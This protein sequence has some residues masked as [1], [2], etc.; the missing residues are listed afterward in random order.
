MTPFSEFV[1]RATNTVYLPGLVVSRPAQRRRKLHGLGSTTSS[2]TTQQYET[3]SLQAA[4]ASAN[5][6][7]AIRV[8]SVPG[9]IGAAGQLAASG[10]AIAGLI[11]GSAAIPVVGAAIAAAAGIASALGVGQGCGSACTNAA[12][13]EQVYEAAA[14][15]L[16]NVAK[17]GLISGQD[18][19]ALMQ[20]LIQMAQ[21]AEASQGTK[22][23]SSGASNAASVIQAE[24][25]SALQFGAATQPFSL[26]AAQAAFMPV[27]TSG[28]YPQ[29]LAA[30]SQLAAQI[31]Q[32]YASS[33]ASTSSLTGTSTAAA[34]PQV[35]GSTAAATT[36]STSTGLFGLSSAALL[37]IGAGV[38]L[39]MM[40]H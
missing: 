16:F 10:T 37:A 38:L 19:A 34:G 39:L 28:W 21:L 7:G 31:L 14:D 33:L 25:S 6:A 18:A 26:A 30:A 27:N 2:S 5:L 3:A 22:Q 29:S 15:N 13:Q 8:G 24:M 32:S 11:A 1:D 20:Q 17:A 35:V 36:T 40:N 23:S 9:E 12:Q 4:G